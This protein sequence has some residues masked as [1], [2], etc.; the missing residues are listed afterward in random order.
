MGILAPEYYEEKIRE[1]LNPQIPT[2]PTTEPPTLAPV[3]SDT[4]VIDQRGIL[5][6][7]NRQEPLGEATENLFI[8][9]IDKIEQSVLNNIGEPQLSEEKQKAKFGGIVGSIEYQQW[10]A[11]NPIKAFGGLEFAKSFGMNLP[12]QETWDRMSVGQKNKLVNV[13]LAAAAAKLIIRLPREVI[14]APIRLGASI[15]QPWVEFAKTGQ[16][17]TIDTLADEEKIGSIPWIGEVPTYWRTY[18]EARDSGLGPLA[19]TI[20][21]GSLAAGDVAI[22][23]AL[24]EALTKSFQPRQS[25]KPGEQAIDVK[26]IE[27]AV[28]TE[29]GKMKFVDKAPD[30]L[31]EYYSLPAVVAK[32]YNGTSANPFSGFEIRGARM[33]ASCAA[34]N[35]FATPPSSRKLFPALIV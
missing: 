22:N 32:K 6:D 14:K 30:S 19:A 25:L 4:K 26:P 5:T 35:V 31:S 7:P 2:T 1:I 13:G 3:S 8:T 18:K 12:D 27:K 16:I 9:P 21:T 28:V 33:S 10:Q 34:V 15:I 11:A 20:S 29:K 24:G 23:A 17:P